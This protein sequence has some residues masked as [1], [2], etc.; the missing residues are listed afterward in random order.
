[1]DLLLPDGGAHN[2]VV[3]ARARPRRGDERPPAN[4]SPTNG[5]Q[6]SLTLSSPLPPGRPSFSRHSNTV[7][8]DASSCAAGC[9]SRSMHCE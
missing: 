7:K 8:P 1:M 5:L 3:V 9:R 4:I 2:L 6:P